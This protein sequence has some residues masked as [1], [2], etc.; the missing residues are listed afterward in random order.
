MAFDFLG[1][2]TKQQVDALR[3]FLQGQ[4]DSVDAQI[5]HLVLETGKLQQTLS[6]LS[7]YADRSNVRFKVFDKSF[8]RATP[9]Q[10]D[11]TDS[12]NLVQL[13][14][15]PFYSNIKVRDDIEH[16]MKKIMDRVEQ[17]QE[18]IHLLRISKSE[19]QTNFETI[20]SLFNSQH[21]Y[22]TTEEVVK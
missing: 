21:T 7:D 4:L 19:F 2:F 18:K 1:I 14:K 3:T 17:I 8:F 15:Q 9:T 13:T 22:L 20:N 12:A 16:R 11:D 5:N 10:V 6:E